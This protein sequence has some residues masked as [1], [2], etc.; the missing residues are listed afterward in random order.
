[1]LKGVSAMSRPPKNVPLS[2]PAPI[3][4]R[5]YHVARRTGSSCRRR[6]YRKFLLL[7]LGLALFCAGFV[8]GSARAAEEENAARNIHMEEPA[9]GTTD[10][11]LQPSS[12]EQQPSGGCLPEGETWELRLVNAAHVLP[13][14]FQVPELTELYGGHAVDSRVYPALQRMMD[15]GRAEGLEPM[16]CSS[17]CTRDKQE[18]LFQNKMDSLL[19]QGYSREDAGDEAARW[20]ARP[21]TSEHET[22]L[23]VDI[24]DTG[25]QLLDQRQETTPVQQ[26]LMDNCAAYGFILRYPT[27]K[28]DLTGIGY[29]PWHYRYVGEE[30]ARTIMEQGLCLEEYLDRW[31]GEMR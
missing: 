24:V 18:E 9:I 25:Y 13:E 26:W 27:D 4:K 14:D 2:R 6:W 30:A 10:D 12:E 28:S 17:Y 3:P 21:G 22:G 29:E 5:E 8:L 15:D 23:A 20:V 16:I 19:T 7:L 1:M 31:A 11:L